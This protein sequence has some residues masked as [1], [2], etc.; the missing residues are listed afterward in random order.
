[1]NSF[2]VLRLRPLDKCL[3]VLVTKGTAYTDGPLLLMKETM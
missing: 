3:V 2:L 1:M